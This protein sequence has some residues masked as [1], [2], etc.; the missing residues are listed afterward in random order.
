MALFFLLGFLCYALLVLPLQHRRGF[1]CTFREVLAVLV[2]MFFTTCALLSKEM[3]VTLPLLCSFWDYFVVLRLSLRHLPS[4]LTFEESVC[5]ATTTEQRRHAT[6]AEDE[7]CGVQGNL[8]Q[9]LRSGPGE[10]A[11]SDVHGGAEQDESRQEPQANDVAGQAVNRP[12]DVPRAFPFADPEGLVDAEAEPAWPRLQAWLSRTLLLATLTVALAIWRAS[13]NGTSPPL[14]RYNANRHALEPFDG[15]V[16]EE[17]TVGGDLGVHGI[18]RWLSIS[19]LWVHYFCFSCL[20]PYTLNCDWSGEAVPLLRSLLDPR[21]VVLLAFLTYVLA[22]VLMCGAG[23]QIRPAPLSA[24]AFYFFPFLLS[25]NVFF[26]VGTT[27]AERVIYLPSLGACMAMAL[28]LTSD[29]VIRLPRGSTPQGG[30]ARGK[31]VLRLLAL[32]VITGG[33]SLKCFNRNLDWTNSGRLWHASW[34][35]NPTSAHAAMNFAVHLT[36]RGTREDYEFAERVLQGIRRLPEVDRVDVDEMYTTLALCLRMLGQVEEALAITA[37]GWDRNERREEAMRNGTLLWHMH[38]LDPKVENFPL[39]RA[40]L[41]AAQGTTLATVDLV[42][43]CRAM[44][45]AVALAPSDQVVQ[46]LATDLESFVRRLLRESSTHEPRYN[47]F[48]ELAEL[49]DQLFTST[50]QIDMLESS[51]P[52]LIRRHMPGLEAATDEQI[53]HVAQ[54][55]RQQVQLLKRN[56]ELGEEH[57]SSLFTWERVQPDKTAGQPWLKMDTDRSSGREDQRDQYSWEQEEQEF[58]GGKESSARGPTREGPGFPLSSGRRQQGSLEPGSDER[59]RR[60]QEK[61]GWEAPET[62]TETTASATARSSGEGS[63]WV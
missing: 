34:R 13:L 60:E 20:L 7:T 16:P 11:A 18:Y 37:E 15:R 42:E 26:P 50:R 55:L 9:D 53:G 24:F 10:V 57:V 14:F 43:A 46:S 36:S 59:R 6:D 22:T 40:R 48:L 31:W 38:E 41:L 44:T 28:V 29:G 1:H 52:V 21:C 33:F 47:V 63:F 51:S 2:C 54:N 25:A 58:P 19:W 61:R 39:R 32:S 23:K 35:L 62:T 3:G 45:S 49:K 27:I 4:V 8:E 12:L 17:L 5:V 56:V 30:S